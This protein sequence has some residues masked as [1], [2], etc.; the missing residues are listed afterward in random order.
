MAHIPGYTYGTTEVARSPVSLEELEQ[1]KQTMHLADEDHEYLRLAGEVLSEQ[2]DELFEYWMSLFGP[3]FM[4]YFQ[5]ADGVPDDQYLGAVHP[6]F[7][8]WIF[9][10]C[11]R[12]YDQEWL[13][14]QHEIGLRHH[15]AKKNQ[16]D[17]VDSVPVVHL[18]YLWAVVPPMSTIRDFLARRGHSEEEVE[19]MHQAWI[20]ALMLSVT[21]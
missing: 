15:R 4:S 2:V 11:N 8:Q 14:Y 19:K 7:V 10:T 6:R 1:L 9:D 13:D 16:T 3:V 20:K 5:G 12:P 17:D 21:L 18:R